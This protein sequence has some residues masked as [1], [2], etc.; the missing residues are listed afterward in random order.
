MP[1][2]AWSAAEAFLARAIRGESAWPAGLAAAEVLEAGAFHGVL[3]LLFHHGHSTAAWQDWP[4]TLRAGLQEAARLNAAL[5]LAQRGETAEVLDA[6][7]ARGVEAIVLKG[8]ALAHTLYP[9]PWLRTRSDTDLLV[10]AADRPAALAA[11]ER[12]GY[13]RSEAAGGELASSEASFSRPGTALPVD[14]HWRINNSALLSSV[15]EFGSLRERAVPVPAL[16]AH[17]RAPGRVDALLLAALHR[18]THHQAPM[19]VDGHAHRGDRLIW[20]YD[21]HLLAP[22]LAPAQVAE[23]ARRAA[24][25]RVAGLCLDALR[26]AQETFATPVPGALAQSLEQDA[27]RPEP[28]MAFLRGGRRGL[29]LAEV[30]ALRGWGERWR[31]LRE[32]AFPPADY[33]LR[34]YSTHRR[35]LL[36]ALYVRRAFGWLAQP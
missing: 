12:L 29:L 8:A 31:L 11:L 16:G 25:G 20:L 13:R 2:P 24:R 33:M 17:A 9:E 4:E 7:A 35:W 28:S 22:R 27:E 18:A 32:H 23:L 3:P 21:L 14:L 15:L 10:R 6:L 34:K 19:R 1:A 5:E 26:A 36:P 30:R